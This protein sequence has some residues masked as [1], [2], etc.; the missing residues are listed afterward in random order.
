ME[1][2]IN[3]FDL[4]QERVSKSSALREALAETICW[5]FVQSLS[6]DTQHYGVARAVAL[7]GLCDTDQLAATLRIS[8]SE[9]K[10]SLR[11]IKYRLRKW[12]EFEPSE[13]VRLAN[14]PEDLALISLGELEEAI[15]VALEEQDADLP[16]EVI[17]WVGLGAVVKKAI[18]GVKTLLADASDLG[19]LAPTAAYFGEGEAPH[20][21]VINLREKFDLDTLEREL[22]W[23]DEAF[24]MELVWSRDA[25]E[26]KD[27]F[28]AS[29]RKRRGRVISA[30]GS[31]LLQV[32]IGQ[33]TQECLLT[34]NDPHGPIIIE[35]SDMTSAP[36]IFGTL[37]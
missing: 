16:E 5:G 24:K 32:Q 6:A 11:E 26:R 21:R 18:A 14:P 7:D 36:K 1:T 25:K 9:V 22:V 17:N 35:D 27:R 3:I 13:A 10:T 4:L 30:R 15:E 2:Q 20:K 8:V 37:K 19:E 29:I 12:K 28:V 31:L 23:A 33:K 34:A